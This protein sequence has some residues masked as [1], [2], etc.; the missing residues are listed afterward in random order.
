MLRVLATAKR[1][2]HATNQ[3][4]RSLMARVRKL[5]ITAVIAV[6]AMALTG[7]VVAAWPA[8][9]SQRSAA[10]CSA[11]A[12]SV[13]RVG[14]FAGIFRPAQ[15]GR[16]H[17]C[18]GAIPTDP[19]NPNGNPPLIN[20]GGPMMSTPAVGDKVVLTPIFWAPTGYTFN[21][22]YK[23]L[24]DRYL[25]DAAHDS[26]KSTNVFSTLFEY[27]GSNGKIN[28]RFSLG[29]PIADTHAFPTGAC[30][31]DPG[32]IYSD[33]SSYSICLD[34]AQVQAETNRVVTA[35]NLARGLG[36]M[37][38]MMLPKGAESC[39]YAT[40]D[41]NHPNNQC[42]LN[43]GPTATYCAYHSEFNANTVYANMPYP[44]YAQPT[45]PF[46]C[47]SEAK[48]PTNESPNGNTDADVE[49]SPLSHEISEAVTDPD[50]STGW[51]DASGN[52]N[53]DEC[54]YE[55]GA[56]AGT[57]GKLYNQTLNGHHY[58]TQEEF[59]N[60]NFAIGKGGCLQHYVAYLKP[61]ITAMSSHAGTS[62]GGQT[63]TIT[64]SNFAATTGVSFGTTAATSFALIDST[65]LKVVTP[66]HAAG[67]VDVTVHNAVGSSALVTA[68]KYTFS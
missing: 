64:G 51:Y 34:D 16:V 47:G 15:T 48:F 43:H 32:P 37:Y 20:H 9:A 4:R 52:E 59:S 3:L 35:G 55:Y 45:I 57:A 54:A 40:G 24:I 56:T 23:S 7:I 10:G 2:D 17:A 33:N 18:T 36:H 8:S 42:T 41:P 50:T 5:P 31:T 60:H 39:F 65:K 68:D 27:S 62:A 61:A 46:T 22:T 63:I 53:G 25:A 28:Y 26:E 49:I 38:I 58:L 30:T 21:A 6:V 13:T 1:V 11:A 67:T 66:A 44:I 12:M 14:K 19:H 29:T